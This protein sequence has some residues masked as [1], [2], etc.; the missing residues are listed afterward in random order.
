MSSCPYHKTQGQAA[1]GIG[2]VEKKWDALD[3]MPLL[4]QGAAKH[5][6]LVTSAKA[7]WR[8]SIR[9]IGRARWQSLKVVDARWVSNVSELFDALEA[10]MSH[11]HEVRSAESM[12]TVFPEYSIERTIRIWNHQLIA[13]ACY[14]DSRGSLL[15]DPMNR[16]LTE[17]ALMLGWVPP[18]E[19]SEFDVLPL[20]VEF[21]GK[22]H[23]KEISSQ[24]K[25]TLR[26]RHPDYPLIETLGLRWY[27][28]PFVADMLLATHSAAYTAAPFNGHYVSTE[29]A[30]RNLSD[31]NR[32][33]RLPEVAHAIGLKPTKRNRL[34]VDRA[35]AV[36]NE[37]VHYSFNDGGYR[38]VDQH[39][40]S[41]EFESFCVKEGHSGREVFG[42]WSWLVP[43]LSG[44]A[45]PVF[46]R[47]F[48]PKLE[49]PNFLY[50]KKAWLSAS[51]RDLLSMHS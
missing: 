29:I 6:D 17:I 49:L 4:S 8:N 48:M 26:I 50:Q 20:I 9:C 31:T 24:Y 42:D 11:A 37:A 5:D 19:R 51:G 1:E 36:L 34:W 30:A 23:L 27:P 45:T 15:G 12:T 10:H 22:L 18:S 46:K 28:I 21:G 32:Y 44:A 41:S 14:T 43:P 35:L 7:A 3:L 38:I 47:Q 16:K 40:V 13:F 39:S 25:Q 2:S 33:N